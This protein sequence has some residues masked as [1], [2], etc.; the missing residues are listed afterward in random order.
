MNIKYLLLDIDG[1]I[2]H[3]GKPTPKI[4]FLLDR[5]IEK[6][7]IIRFVTNCSLHRMYGFNKNICLDNPIEIIDPISVFEYLCKTDETFRNECFAIVATKEIKQRIWE[8]GLNIVDI[9]DTKKL[10]I[11]CYLKRKIMTRSK[12]RKYPV[13]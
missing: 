8:L 2:T 5:I 10:T 6:G 12:L 4:K 11:Y 13:S 1:V 3:Q 9:N 7:I